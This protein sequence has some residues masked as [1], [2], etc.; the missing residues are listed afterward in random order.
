MLSRQGCRPLGTT[1]SMGTG[2]QAAQ[3]AWLRPSLP[4][5]LLLWRNDD[6]IS[7]SER[8]QRNL[9]FFNFLLFFFLP[10]YS[11]TNEPGLVLGSSG[12]N[13]PYACGPTWP[14]GPQGKA[15]VLRGPMPSS[16]QE[17]RERALGCATEIT[18]V[19]RM[20]ASFINFIAEKPIWLPC[21]L[22]R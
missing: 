7:A 21:S 11:P 18:A 12:G 22:A 8:R 14:L 15:A 19:P 13:K 6:R 16:L 3:T 1:A 10:R 9:S 4:A 2:D 5:R 20:P 17:T